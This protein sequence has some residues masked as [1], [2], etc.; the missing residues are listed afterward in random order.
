MSL[1]GVTKV[2]KEKGD[3]EEDTNTGGKKGVKSKN[4]VRKRDKRKLE[5]KEV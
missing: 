3:G 1:G 5:G 4:M 2:E